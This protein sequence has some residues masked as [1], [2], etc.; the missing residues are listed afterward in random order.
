MTTNRVQAPRSSTT[1]EVPPAGVQTGTVAVNL[2]DRKVWAY[3]EAGTPVLVSSS[4]YTWD[5]ARIY[6]LNDWAT[7]G[8]TIYRCV[9]TTSTLGSFIL[10]EWESFDVSIVPDFEILA[11]Y[12]Q[13]TLVYFE[14]NLWRADGVIS[15][16]PFDPDDW[17][18]GVTAVVFV[19][20]LPPTTFT[21]RQLWYDDVAG[22]LNLR[23]SPDWVPLTAQTV[24]SVFGRVG[25][26]IANFADYKAEQV[27]FDDTVAGTGENEVQGVLD[28]ILSGALIQVFSVHGR[29]GIVVSADLDYDALQVGYDNTTTGLTAARVQA[30]IDELHG[31]ITASGVES[32]K[33]RTGIVVPLAD[34]YTA[35]EVTVTPSGNITAVEVQAALQELDNAIETGVSTVFTR[36]G[37]V[38]AEEGDYIL[39]LLGDVDLTA[40]PP[41]ADDILQFDGANFVPVAVGALATTRSV[42]ARHSVT[43]DTPGGVFITAL[44]D[45][46][47][48]DDF[49]S[50]PLVAGVFTAPVAGR[51]LVTFNTECLLS[52]GSDAVL[53]VNYGAQQ[54][55]Y[56]QN[57]AGNFRLFFYSKVLDL[58]MNDTVFFEYAQFVVGTMTLSADSTT[59][60]ITLMG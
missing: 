23:I 6:L 45:T 43:Q 13:G 36:T 26:V 57:M 30:A 12:A 48:F 34:D 27:T 2:V 29:T 28:L 33:G 55:S 35:S 22:I 11:T 1:G 5:V 15:P 44:F 54:V 37:D 49:P 52:G 42:I 10:S 53:Q 14:G 9:V 16:G 60:S 24:D 51:Y 19:G 59:I 38:V 50:T 3:T 47:E 7:V 18:E 17:T 4:L 41:V 39:D 56:R 25:D 40:T 58:A 32:W 31:I 46:I 20:P 21:E 8:Q